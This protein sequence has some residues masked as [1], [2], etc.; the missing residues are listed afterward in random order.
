M[1]RRKK[2]TEVG[3][4]VEGLEC[5]GWVSRN[6]NRSR[7]RFALVYIPVRWRGIST[8]TGIFEASIMR[9]SR[10][11]DDHARTSVSAI[12][13]DTLTTPWTVQVERLISCLITSR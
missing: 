5:I 3:W 2:I 13:L 9:I 11:S 7:R 12:C 1:G 4:Q 8:S 6:R 10:L